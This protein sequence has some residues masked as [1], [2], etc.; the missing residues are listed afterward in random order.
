MKRGT[1]QATV[2]RVAKNQTCLSPAWHKLTNKVLQ[3]LQIKNDIDFIG[4]VSKRTSKQIATTMNSNS[5]TPWGGEQLNFG[6]IILYA[7]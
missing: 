2:H 6:I 5:N 3:R 1:W 7:V 4:L